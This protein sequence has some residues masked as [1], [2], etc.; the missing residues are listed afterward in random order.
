MLVAG[1]IRLRI[2]SSYHKRIRLNVPLR[3]A[4]ACISLFRAVHVHLV[5]GKNEKNPKQRKGSVFSPPAPSF[6][7]HYSGKQKTTNKKEQVFI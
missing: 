7:H 6:P 1:D 5:K 2:G 4:I 3:G